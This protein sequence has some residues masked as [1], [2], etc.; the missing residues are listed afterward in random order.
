M[1][2][3]TV[4]TQLAELR[5]YI[6]AV[7]EWVSKALDLV[8]QIQEQVFEI[9]EKKMERKFVD[10]EWESTIKKALEDNKEV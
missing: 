4:H 7:D 3:K 8:D 1:Q 6:K 9:E 2:K 5:V 10:T